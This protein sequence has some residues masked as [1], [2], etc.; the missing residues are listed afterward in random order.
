MKTDEKSNENIKKF[1]THKIKLKTNKI[2]IT[3]K[4]KVT[5]KY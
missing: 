5:I 1:N 3:E 2:A 4:K